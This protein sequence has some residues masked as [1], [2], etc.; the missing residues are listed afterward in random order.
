MSAI[1]VDRKL[2]EACK[3]A[4]KQLIKERDE[5]TCQLVLTEVRELESK[6]PKR[7]ITEVDDPELLAAMEATKGAKRVSRDQIFKTLRGIS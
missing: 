3:L 5:A 1:K 6:K 7:R 4:I 2:V